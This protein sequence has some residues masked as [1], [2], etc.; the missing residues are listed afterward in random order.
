MTNHTPTPR[1]QEPEDI[2]KRNFIK[3][4]TA[5][6]LGFLSLALTWPLVSF[7]VP[8]EN[9]EAEGKF[10]KVPHFGSIPTGKPTKM[11]F[12]DVDKQ[13]FIVSNIVYDI[14]VIKHSADKATVYAP[15]CPHLNC[16]YTFLG[17]KDQFA[18]PCHGSVFS[19]DGKVLG[20]PAP[21]PLDTLAHKIEGGELYVQWKLFKAGVA[22]KIEI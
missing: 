5:S 4:V 12:V 10:I 3:G 14:W 15:L 22:E 17:D 2:Q 1:S 11:T 7:L 13:A 6:I 18:C 8:A 21:R 20:G 9:Q 16:R 19:E